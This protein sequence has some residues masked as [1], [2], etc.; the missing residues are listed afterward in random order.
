MDALSSAEIA[1]ED[2]VF[3][4]SANIQGKAGIPAQTT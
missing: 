1:P 3:T 2:N 4:M